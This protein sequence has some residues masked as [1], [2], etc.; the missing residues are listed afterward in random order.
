M[1]I[2]KADLKEVLV[3]E[4]DLHK[5]ERGWFFESYSFKKYSEYGISNTFIQDNH[6]LSVRKGVLRGI[7]FQNNPYAQAKLV[8]CVKGKI[9]DVAIDLRK[10]S[11]TFKKWFAIELSEDNKKQ[12]Y[13]PKGFGHAFLTLTNN[14]EVEYKVDEIYSKSHDRA[15]AYND[16]N[17]NIEWTL[18][19]IILSEKDLVAPSLKDSDVNFE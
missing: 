9:L 2:T 8:R 5:D 6:S 13:I 19:K 3:I 1:K 15:I 14:C 11:K 16:Q 7:H 18:K 4:P 17:I 12:L 10:S